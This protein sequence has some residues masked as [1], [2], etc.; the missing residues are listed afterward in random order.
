MQRIVAGDTRKGWQQF[1]GDTA[2]AAH[3]LSRRFHR[4]LRWRRSTIDDPVRE[5]V[6]VPL[7][8]VTVVGPFTWTD[9]QWNKIRT[10]CLAGGS[11]VFSL[12]EGQP[13]LRKQVV[14]ALHR[15]FPEYRLAPLP[16]DAPE[17]TVETEIDPRPDVLAMGNGFRRFVYLPRREWSCDW[18][19]Y[20]LEDQPAGFAF[21]Y[22]L[23]SAN[24]DGEPPESAFALSTYPERSVPAFHMQTV[25]MEIGGE[26]PAYPTVLDLMDRL[27]Q[28]NYRLGVESV[29][30]ETNAHLLWV[31][32]TGKG[33]VSAEEKK[34][35]AKALEAGTFVFVDVVSGNEEWDRATREAL[36]SIDGVTLEDLR[37]TDP[38][39]TGEIPGTQGFDVVDVALRRALHTRLSHSGR[40]ALYSVRYRG[41]HA[42]VYSAYDIASGVGYHLFPGCRGVMPAD[43]RKLAMNVFLDAYRRRVQESQ[44]N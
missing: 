21:L 35:I 8:L 19:L 17:F 25:R 37:R 36:S 32:V 13:D 15:T 18:H 27:L 12:P 3:D 9:A 1:R 5:L 2:H 42:G 41:K 38:V 16:D 43:A 39:F 14:D 4:P 22:N 20:R 11:V 29:E 24:T 23:L 34:R 7:M 30:D 44:T 33:P 40:C 31:S 26:V 10:Y 28:S 6:R